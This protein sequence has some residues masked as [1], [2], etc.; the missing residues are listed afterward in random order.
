MG[1]QQGRKRL[2][3]KTHKTSPRPNGS[4]RRGELEKQKKKRGTAQPRKG[5]G[6]AV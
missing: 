5:S 2:I 3:E 4:I 1:G 6:Q